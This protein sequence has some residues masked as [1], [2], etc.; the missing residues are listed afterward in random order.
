MVNPEII[1]RFANF[2]D[3][4]DDEIKAMA[5]L[6]NEEHYEPGR[7]IFYEGDEANKMY[8]LLQ[9]QVEMMLNTDEMGA[10][11]ELVMTVQPNEIF[12][13][14]ALVE[15]YKLT[16]SARC[17]TPVRVIGIA[18]PG[19]RALM[20]VSCALGFRLLQRACQASSARLNAT[21]V[22]LLSAVRPQ[23]AREIA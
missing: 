12:G 9:G 21:R 16:A 3:F 22:Q 19:L 6:A 2:S 5:I 7:F 20:A 17:A 18:A 4:T 11:R 8:L 10:Q 23:P 15:P 14:S 13:W 1:A